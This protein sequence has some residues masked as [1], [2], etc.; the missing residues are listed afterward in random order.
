VIN[1]GLKQKDLKLNY[2]SGYFAKTTGAE[3]ATRKRVQDR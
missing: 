2:R 1:P 3:P